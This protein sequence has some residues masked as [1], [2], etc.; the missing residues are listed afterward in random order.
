MP[1]T[2]A[3]V[4]NS[5]LL[6]AVALG[7]LL[8]AGC[9][10]GDSGNCTVKDRGDETVIICPDGSE[11]TVTDGAD[12]ADGIDGEDG[13]SCRAVDNEHGTTDI[14]CD[15]GNA[16]TV[17]G[18]ECDRWE[19]SLF[20]TNTGDLTMLE[21]LGC[22]DIT[23]DLIVLS[24][25][26]SHL[27]GLQTVERVFG[28]V[29]IADNTALANLDGLGSLA[30]IGGGLHIENNP[31]LASLSGLSGITDIDGDLRILLSDNEALDAI[32]AFDALEQLHGSLHITGG[33]GVETIEGFGQLNQIRGDLHIIHNPALVDIDGFDSLELTGGTLDISYNPALSSV[34]GFSSLEAIDGHFHIVANPSLVGFDAFHALERTHHTEFDDA[35]DETEFDDANDEPDDHHV[36]IWWNESLPALPDFPALEHVFGRLS[37]GVNPALETL[38]P[39]ASLQRVDGNLT[40]RSNASI[41]ELDAFDELTEV[42][43]RINFGGSLPSV[44]DLDMDAVEQWSDF[45]DDWSTADI[46][47][48]IDDSGLFH[49]AGLTDAGS[50]PSLQYAGGITF[51]ENQSLMYSPSFDALEEL[52]GQL[53]YVENGELTLIDGFN[54]LV[55][56]DADIEILDNPEL[57]G[58]DGFSSLVTTGG[59]IWIRN[60]PLLYEI[61]MLDDLVVIEVDSPSFDDGLFIQQNDELE[62][63]SGFSSL[64]TID[65]SLL[66]SNN[67]LLSQCDVDDLFGDVDVQLFTSFIGNDEDC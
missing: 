27:D 67:P 31:Q 2:R 59:Y 41:D 16:F 18:G 20:V 22:R 17:P 19:G 12:G 63:L 21:S 28:D 54:A 24:N 8:A 23:G 51:V 1:P 29:R 5:R 15:E 13:A 26:L 32:D 34:S 46:A 10:I 39:F 61:S 33:Y 3:F 64:N 14:V 58:I 25:G 42:N 49:Q 57:T 65:G 45:D 7:A 30:S 56:N 40:L 6:A 66:V 48:W 43:G 53:H 60:N 55:D 37:I 4:V 9:N 62:E 36:T 11:S 38:P 44:G 35:N 50:F 52:H 47:D